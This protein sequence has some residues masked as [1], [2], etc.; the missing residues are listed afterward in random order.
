M[1]TPHLD[2]RVTFE[3]ATQT[4]GA[5]GTTLSWGAHGGVVWAARR[6]ISDGERWRA[7]EVGAAISTRF[8]VRWNSFTRGLTPADRLACEGVTYDITGIK[9]IGPR[10]RFLEITASARAD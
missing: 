3:R 7:G 1:D 2:R 4:A 9:E 6:D 8:I 5:L 10:R